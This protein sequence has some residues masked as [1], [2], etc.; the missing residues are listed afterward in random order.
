M[1]RSYIDPVL[2]DL[3]EMT[4]SESKNNPMQKYVAI[5]KSKQ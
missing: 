4:E 5:V 1:K 2:G 3:L